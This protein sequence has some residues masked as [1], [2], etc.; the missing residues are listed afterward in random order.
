MTD[1]QTLEE[2]AHNRTQRPQGKVFRKFI[3]EDW[4]ERPPGP[5][6]M[7]VADYTPARHAAFSDAFA[8]ERLVFPAGDLVVRTND[9]DHRFRANSTFAYLTG[10]GGEDEPG[11]VVV[12]HPN[13][14]GHEAVL[15]FHPRTSRSSE[16]FFADARH[17]EFWVGARASL[18]EM[19]TLT[20]MTVKHIDD[21]RDDLSANLESTTIRLLAGV[22]PTI[23]AMVSDL[24]TEAGQADGAQDA[25][26]RLAEVASEIRM[27]K[28]DFEISQM[29]KAVDV[30]AEGFNEIILAIPRAKTHWRGER[31]L[32]TAFESKARE[33][34]NGVGYD[35]IIA[36]GNHA[37][38]LHWINND[39]PVNEGDLVLIDAGIEIDSL[40]TG[41]ITRTFPVSG[42]FTDAQREV[43]DVVVEALETCFQVAQEKVQYK[44]IHAAA[45]EV[46][47]K[48]LERW[49]MLPVSAKEALKPDNQQH[50]R[51]MP[52]GT[53]HHLG[54]DV[55]DCAQASREVYQE[56]RLAPGM[57]FTIE[58]GLYFRE[59][60]LKVPERF[61]GI[62]IRVEDNILV[63]EDGAIRL[64]EAIPR[65]ADDVEQW[66]A[67]LW[68]QGA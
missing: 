14:D 67:D 62:G 1:E 60:D 47:A 10:L 58:P 33:E 21:L 17:G 8:S 46:F 28:D 36:S 41:D 63:T 31:V 44:E 48:H 23:D 38:T 50:R 61:R 51:W 4:G 27:I 45:M 66:M 39:G 64:S 2:K 25:D 54:L 29:Q 20:G 3:G 26:D 37:N 19:E 9:T 57:I 68:A 22:D 7:E 12:L 5:K 13:D 24:R 30:T 6:R 42:T 59:D 40:Y 11:A 43:Y 49:G 16:E 53:G 15:Y 56:S 34:G 65:T 52:H 32:E 18:E 35:T 55:H